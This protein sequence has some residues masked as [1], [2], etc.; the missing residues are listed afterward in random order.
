MRKLKLET[1]GRPFSNDDLQVLQNL[2]DDAAS[3]LFQGN[4]AFVVSGCEVA[5]LDIAPGVVFIDGVLS[6]FAGTT[7]SS[8]PVYMHSGDPAEDALQLH[9]D[10]LTKATQEEMVVSVAT[11]V[12]GSGE[13]IT[14]TA[15][16]GRDFADIIN[17]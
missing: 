10:G 2:T 15:S 13:Y 4:G 5:G 14:F 12:P 16:G 17:E 6:K 7:V 1:G 3:A 9:E 11:S 8:F